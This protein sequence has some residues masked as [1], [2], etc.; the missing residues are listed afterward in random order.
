MELM[1]AQ[2]EALQKKM[3]DKVQNIYFR[4]RQYSDLL[5]FFTTSRRQSLSPSVSR[6]P[7]R[8]SNGWI[9]CGKRP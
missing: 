1:K 7:R 9:S 8:S 4:W 6:W 2:M 3:Q 5:L